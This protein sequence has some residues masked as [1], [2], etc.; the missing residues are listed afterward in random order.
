MLVAMACTVHS[1]KILSIRRATFKLLGLKI[2]NMLLVFLYLNKESG[3][4]LFAI[5]GYSIL[6]R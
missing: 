3:F 2:L 4:T 5:M 1:L 6:L